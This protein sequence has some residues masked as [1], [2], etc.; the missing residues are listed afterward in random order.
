[1][2]DLITQ[3]FGTHV[4]NMSAKYEVAYH[5]YPKANHERKALCELST[6]RLGDLADMFGQCGLCYRESNTPGYEWG[7]VAK[8][9]WDLDLRRT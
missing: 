8:E 1:M 6:G 7:M 2:L 9:P 5:C 3:W 4:E